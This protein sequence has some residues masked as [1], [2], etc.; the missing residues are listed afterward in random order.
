MLCFIAPH[1]STQPLDSSLL[2][3][4]SSKPADKSSTAAAAA[5]TEGLDKEQI[6]IKTEPQGTITLQCVSFIIL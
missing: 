3:S 2:E 1:L 4:P 6:T 5:S